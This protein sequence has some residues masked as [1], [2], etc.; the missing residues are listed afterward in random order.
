MFEVKTSKTQAVICKI[1]TKLL[2]QNKMNK[3]VAKSLNLYNS[4]YKL[5]MDKL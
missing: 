4:S 2:L 1:L 5:K 3:I